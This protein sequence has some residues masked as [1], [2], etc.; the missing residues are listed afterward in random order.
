MKDT[1]TEEFGFVSKNN[2][3]EIFTHCFQSQIPLL[4]KGPTGC[5]K[6]RLVEFMAHRLAR[7]LVKVSC[8]EDTNASDLLGRFLLKGNDTIWSDGPVTRAVRSNA[9]LYL[10]E[11]AEARED[12]IVAIH[13]LSDH[14]RELYID[15]INETLRAE[16]NFMLVASYNP[17]YQR[18]IRELKPSTKQRFVT[19]SMDY[20]DVASEQKIIA[21]Q[22]GVNENIARS[23]AKLA[24]KIRTQSELQLNETVSTRLLIH[25]AKLIRSGIKP[26]QA[27]HVAIAEVLSDDKQIVAAIKDFIDL[28]M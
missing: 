15:K 26:R 7:P 20:L 17:G 27:G 8:N 5:G 19:V 24:E 4:L 18:G 11:F 22:T 13:P 25:T 6:S 10:D 9:I 1:S 21:D 23:L 2:E 16:A 28:S 3:I 12:V 14:R